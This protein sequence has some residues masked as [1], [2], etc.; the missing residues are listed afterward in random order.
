M[1]S[2]KRC[3]RCAKVW[4]YGEGENETFYAPFV[5][6]ADQLPLTGNILVTEGGLVRVFATGVASDNVIAD[7]KSARVVEVTHTTPAEKVF[8]LVI[9]DAQPPPAGWSI[10]R[11]ERLRTLDP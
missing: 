4:S 7:K 6:D 8:E 2:T 1:R 3:G 9:D 11:A 10:Y 5:G